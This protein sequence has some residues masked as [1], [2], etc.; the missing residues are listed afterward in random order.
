MMM[1]FFKDVMTS[2]NETLYLS[3]FYGMKVDT[4]PKYKKKLA[5]ALETLGQRY[6]LHAPVAKVLK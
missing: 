5:N 4:D 1:N 3:N 2:N 6:V